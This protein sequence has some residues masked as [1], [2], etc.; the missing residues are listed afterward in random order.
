[1]I[2]R[3]SQEDLHMLMKNLDVRIEELKGL[4]QASK[5]I[6]IFSEGEGA[7]CL[8]SMCRNSWMKTAKQSRR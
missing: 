7:L 3:N 1:M 5:V 2:R 6:G 8:Y 4:T